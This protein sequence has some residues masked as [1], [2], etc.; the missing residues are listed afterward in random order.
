M[1]AS[2]LPPPTRRG[3]G[4]VA[5]KPDQS[6]EP[7]GG[8]GPKCP[9]GFARGALTTFVWFGVEPAA[10]GAGGVGA[11]GAV[12]GSEPGSCPGAFEPL[13]FSPGVCD[14]AQLGPSGGVSVP[15][16]WSCRSA[17]VF[18]TTVSRCAPTGVVELRTLV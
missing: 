17:C 6:S 3:A 7:G 8:G 4:L 18:P 5:P 11:G 10:L 12:G 16:C 2:P 1:A 13:S 15:A 14:S 9:R